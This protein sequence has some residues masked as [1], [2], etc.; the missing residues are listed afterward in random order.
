LREAAR[1]ASVSYALLSLVETGKRK[2]TPAFL[3]KLAPVLSILKMSSRHY[4]AL[5]LWESKGF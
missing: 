5:Q 2:P 4:Q 3:L 1:K